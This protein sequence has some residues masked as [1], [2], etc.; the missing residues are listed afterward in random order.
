MGITSSTMFQCNLEGWSDGSRFS[1][2]V[3]RWRISCNT[4]GVSN[5]TLPRCNQ[6]LQ[7]HLCLGLVTDGPLQPGT[8]GCSNRRRST[9]VPSLD[10][11]QHLLNGQRW[12]TGIA[13]PRRTAFNFVSGS[14]TGRLA[15]ALPKHSPDPLTH[16]QAFTPGQAL[17][18]GHFGIGKQHLKTLTHR[19]SMA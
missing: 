12:G 14:I 4:S 1:I 8:S 5:E 15:R 7:N 16:C 10:L 11:A 9:L 2:A 18:L 17:D 19:V 3:Y 6:A 13:P